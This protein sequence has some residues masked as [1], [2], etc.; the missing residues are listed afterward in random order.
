MENFFKLSLTAKII[1][2]ILLASMVNS[3]ILIRHSESELHS[4]MLDQVKKQALVYLQGIAWEV[5]GLIH[6]ISAQDIQQVIQKRYQKHQDD[7][8]DFAVRS[9]YVYDQQGIIIASSGVAEVTPKDMRGYYGDV[10]R[11]A[12]PYL[13]KK[14]EFFPE[15]DGGKQVAVLDV[16]I[17][18]RL[19]SGVVG[20]MEA[21]IDMDKT[22]AIIQRMDDRYEY[23]MVWMNG[24]HAM[25]LSGIFVWLIHRLLIRHVKH[26]DAVTQ[27]VGGGLFSSRV[28]EPMPRDELGRLG[29]SINRMTESIERLMREQEE[30]YIQSLRS[31]T[32]ALEAKDA[33]TASHSSRVSAFSVR[34]GD[35]LGLDAEKLELLRKG[36]LMHDLGKI[37]IRDVLLNKPA[38]LDDDEFKEMQ[39]HPSHTAAIMRPLKRFKEFMEIAAWHHERWDGQGYPDGLH[40]EEIPL[41]A[42][43]VS[44]ADTW[45]AMTG[46][47]V[48]R[49]GMSQEKALAIFEREW[50]SGQWDP[51]LVQQFVRMIRENT[52][53]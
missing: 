14:I 35:H 49:K 6:P 23:T 17:P 1:V 22:L 24:L 26:Y 53:L 25:V 46:D 20:G 38:P 16:I 31:L 34:L 30:A 37:G 18:L 45:D 40:G 12:Q 52:G 44:I 42:R 8:L 19:E 39:A 21:E 47:R 11:H 41:L 32:R 51:A 50:D 29:G 2:F 7:T 15:V 36:A 33:Y 43:I 4:V 28:M 3:I 27:A 10:I 5:R 9:L 48:Y 13:S